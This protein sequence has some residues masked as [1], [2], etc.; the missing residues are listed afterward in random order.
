[1][2]EG[3]REPTPHGSQCAFCGIPNP[4]D[5]H[6]QQHNAQACHQWLS[7]SFSS[8]R[9]HELVYHLRK[10]HGIESKHQGESIAVKWK[11]TVEKQ[12][13]SCGFCVTTFT[14]F[15]ERLSHIATQHFE[16]GQTIDEWDTTKVIQGLLRQPG[17]I[18]S[19]EG[20]LRSLQFWEIEDIMWESHAIVDIQHDLEV[21]PSDEKR[22]IDL[23]EAAYM[24]CRLNLGMDT[25]RVGTNSGAGLD[26]ILDMTATLPNQSRASSAFS[27]YLDPDHHHP[28]SAIQEFNETFD[29]DVGSQA[30]HAFDYGY[31]S[32]PMASHQDLDA[33]LFGLQ[34][35]QS[36]TNWQSNN[37]DDGENDTENNEA[38]PGTF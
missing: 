9:R 36:T 25:E 38:W 10:V 1:M 21:G 15:N 27:P 23:V 33:S 14:S 18:E 37:D 24:A 34:Q 5:D 20:K 29:S 13:W 3:P 6:F 2:L 30:H 35:T 4:E 17:L 19:W 32:E 7:D 31:S 11:N 8:K 12:A 28:L 26:R 16:R 22:A